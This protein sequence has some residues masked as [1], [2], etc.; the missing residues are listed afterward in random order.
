MSTSDK[1]LTD[2]LRI[3]HELERKLDQIKIEIRKK[4][5]EKSKS[6]H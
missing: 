6:K 5:Y 4:I 3:K 2:L 1:E